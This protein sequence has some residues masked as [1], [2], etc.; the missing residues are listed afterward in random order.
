MTHRVFRATVR[1][2]FPTTQP[3]ALRNLLMHFVSRFVKV[4]ASHGPE[5]KFRLKVLGVSRRR[6]RPESV[7]SAWLVMYQ[8]RK[9]GAKR[10]PLRP[11][12]PEDEI[13][14]RR[15]RRSQQAL[16][17]SHFSHAWHCLQSA[18][19]AVLNHQQPETPNLLNHS[20]HLRRGA[21]TV[22]THHHVSEAGQQ[23]LPMVFIPKTTTR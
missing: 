20:P 6:Y 13:Q 12:P 8:V 15:H 21:Q 2:L 16:P 17:G 3:C 22:M 19:K 10:D 4:A 5:S 9:P 18:D 14:N 23:R 1:L 11:P 7:S